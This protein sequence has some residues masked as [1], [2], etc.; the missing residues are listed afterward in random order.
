MKSPYRIAL[1]EVG[2]RGDTIRRLHRDCFPYDSPLMPKMGWWW[3]CWR[4]GEA[5]GFA[6]MYLSSRW[7]DT[8]YLCRAGILPEH[9]GHG[10][11]RRLIRARVRMA[12]SIGMTWAVTDTRQNAS[13]ANN[14]IREGFLMI[15][16]S[17]P[18]SFRDACYWARRLQEGPHGKP[19][20]PA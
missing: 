14:L 3:I 7:T 10:L 8:V 4:G 1:A 15:Q 11:Q 12:R 13:S 2:D 5:V 9:R 6:G 16:P 19:P 18:W 20:P 17:T